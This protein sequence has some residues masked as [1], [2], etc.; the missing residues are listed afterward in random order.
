MD[1]YGAQQTALPWAEYTP[2]LPTLAENADPLPV[3]PG[4]FPEENKA[5]D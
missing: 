3:I 1:A 5:K 4:Y 2:E